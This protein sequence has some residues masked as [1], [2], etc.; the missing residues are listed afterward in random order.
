MAGK[1]Y[2][3]AILAAAL[4]VT[5]PFASCTKETELDE[6]TPVKEG[7]VT[8]FANLLDTKTSIDDN[9]T[10][11][12][13]ETGDR[14]SIYSLYN[15]VLGSTGYTL[16]AGEG[17]PEGTFSG[18]AAVRGSYIGAFYPYTTGLTRQDPKDSGHYAFQFNLPRWQD[19]KSGST[20]YSSYDYKVAASYEKLNT[21]SYKMTFVQKLSLLDFRLVL[22]PRMAS[23]KFKSF[24][25]EAE[26]R[27][28]T[29]D[30]LM[31][32]KAV[33]EAVRPG[34]EVSDT[35]SVA[36]GEGDGMDS[37]SDGVL[38]FRM[39]TLPEIKEDDKLSFKLTC[40][41]KDYCFDLHAAK[42]YQGGYRYTMSI[43]MSVLESYD[44]VTV[45]KHDDFFLR[46]KTPGIFNLEEQ[47]FT[48]QN[49]SRWQFGWS[50]SEFRFQN[51]QDKK[52][53][54]ISRPSAMEVGTEVSLSVT[55]I[56]D[57]SG[58]FTHTTKANVVKVDAL[59]GTCWLQ[60]DINGYGYILIAN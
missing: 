7:G 22:S 54:R 19:Q 8:I 33:D 32:I 14:I 39:V 31:D 26:G 41:G 6:L 45:I 11:V 37:P 53:I 10:T 36:L 3:K 34:T 27:A 48:I 57:V 47:V 55:T 60:D 21:K 16:S 25:M 58:D 9:G 17:T 42:D 2:T 28:V 43:D 49:D 24:K 29:G 18:N 56:G 30:F 38:H 44:K 1:D 35:V 12:N 4:M 15:G 50:T 59:T 20:E 46:F 5:L 23:D 52:V 51:W 13:W 40:L